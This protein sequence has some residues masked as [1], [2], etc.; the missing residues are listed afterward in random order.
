MASPALP[1]EGCP[2]LLLL[3]A[4][5]AAGLAFLRGFLSAA[6]LAGLRLEP[7]AGTLAVDLGVW[8]VLRAASGL[9]SSSSDSSDSSDSSEDSWRGGSQR[10]L[11]SLWTRAPLAWPD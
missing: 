8:G 2:R 9:S 4:G 11:L 10:V 5:F 1:L 3:A 7:D 6:V